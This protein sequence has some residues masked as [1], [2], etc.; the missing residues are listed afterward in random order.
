MKEEN[1]STASETY[2]RICEL[3][4]EIEELKYLK[5]YIKDNGIMASVITIRIN[6]GF[7]F[8]DRA[9]NGNCK[10]VVFINRLIDGL[11]KEVESLLKSEE[12]LLQSL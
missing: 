7:A 4:K 8:S 6:T 2:M 10:N 5:R 12:L 3:R 1:M 9:A 11:L